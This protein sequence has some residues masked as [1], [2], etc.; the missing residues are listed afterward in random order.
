[1]L[2]PR[3]RQ[4]DRLFAGVMVL[5]V[6]VI[7]LLLYALIG[8]A[9][10]LI[11]LPNLKISFYSF[12]LWDDNTGSLQCHQFPE[13]ETLGVSPVGLALAIFCVNVALV[14]TLFVPL[15]LLCAR[16]NSEEA[17]WQLAVGFLV[18]ASVLLLGGLAFFLICARKWVR[19][20]LLGPGFLALIIALA[21]LL[22]LSIT[23]VLFPRRAEEDKSQLK[24]HDCEGSS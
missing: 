5:V 19:L 2:I 13:M 22:L 7:A 14:L 11:D 6:V 18:M 8:K 15:S 10:N 23:T 1:M 16:Y 4:S 20:S 3:L 12:C 17:E 21:L 9:G 24:I